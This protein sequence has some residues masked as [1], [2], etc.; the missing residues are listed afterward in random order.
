MPNATNHETTRPPATGAPLSCCSP[1]ALFGWSPPRLPADTALRRR[2]DLILPSSGLPLI[3]FFGAVIALLNVGVLLPT[4]LDLFAVGLAAVA[5]GSWCSAN[6]WRTR[7]AHCVITAAG[8]L[9]LAAFSFLETG[10]GRSL[11]HGDE[12][13]V[14]LG[15]LAAGLVFEGAWYV[16]RGT[17]AVLSGPTAARGHGDPRASSAEARSS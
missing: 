7:H 11:I 5:A 17:N 9:A 16:V 3:I 6:F 4:R 15:V 1:A 10:L 8:W 13:L 2:V 12:G 14:F